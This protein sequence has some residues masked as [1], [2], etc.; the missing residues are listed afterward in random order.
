MVR[1]NIRII[2]EIVLIDINSVIRILK[3]L[4][5]I[6]CF[7]LL[8]DTTELTENAL[9]SSLSSISSIVNNS[10][11]SS[12]DNDVAHNDI[13]QSVDLISTI[14]DKTV[15]FTNQD[16]ANKT[17]QVMLISLNIYSCSHDKRLYATKGG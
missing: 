1:N 16:S 17:T 2:S 9:E 11:T 15:N 7:Q 4:L 6:L 8:N 5:I 3:I 13:I 10:I 14:S 12:N